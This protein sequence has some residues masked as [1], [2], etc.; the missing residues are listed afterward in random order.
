LAGGG[1]LAALV[2]EK[3]RKPPD[4]AVE[5][6]I[7]PHITTDFEPDF[8]YL[9][10]LAAP[11]SHERPEPP[12][13]DEDAND[14]AESDPGIL[15]FVAAENIRYEAEAQRDTFLKVSTAD[16]SSLSADEKVAIAAGHRIPIESWRQD[17][18]GHWAITNQGQTYYL[19][20]A[21]FKL[22]GPD[23]K[24]L[25]T[26]KP[27]RPK[28]PITLVTG[29]RVD[30]DDA[31]LGGGNFTWSEATR[32]G[33]RMPESAAVVA[34][35]RRAAQAMQDI[36]QRLGDRPITVT[37]W[38][39]PPAVNRR[40][41][42]AS[43]SRHLFGDAVDFVVSGIPATEVERRLDAWWGARGGLA[44]SRSMGFTHIDLRGV[45]ARWNY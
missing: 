16:S 12:L 37:S 6:A 10:S 29:E 5:D 32:G 11:E 31:I 15:E 26:A 4:E 33:E 23:G 30:L 42:G 2:G 25:G 14:G 9:A 18:D 21:H 19:F 27:H 28:R 24:E 45:A 40:V 20:S 36:R 43:Q 44:S 39:R 17:D 38:Y 34:Q 22:L 13:G 1:I 41:G 35:I 8:A 3:K 7:A